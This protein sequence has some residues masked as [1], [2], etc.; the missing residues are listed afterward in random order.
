M[1]DNIP[2]EE[3]SDIDDNTFKIRL[4]IAGIFLLLVILFDQTGKTFAGISVEQFYEAIALDYGEVV[5]T[6]AQILQSHS[7]DSTQ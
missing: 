1:R 5:E 2:V 6:Y 7:Y 4:A 3:K